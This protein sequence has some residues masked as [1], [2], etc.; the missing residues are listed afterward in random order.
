M[1]GF[2]LSPGMVELGEHNDAQLLVLPVPPLGL[3][4]APDLMEVGRDDFQEREKEQRALAFFLPI[5]M[6]RPSLSLRRLTGGERA[7]AFLFA[8]I[9]FRARPPRWRLTGK[10]YKPEKWRERAPFFSHISLVSGPFSTLKVN[11]DNFE[12]LWQKQEDELMALGSRVRI[13]AR[14]PRWR[15]IGK[16]WK[17]QGRQ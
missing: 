11:R 4:K 17:P 2:V 8:L 16:L 14:P 7:E 5:F 6:G 13:R 10:L 1:G 9:S 15:L 12:G 3:P